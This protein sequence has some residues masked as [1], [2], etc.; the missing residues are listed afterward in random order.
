MVLPSVVA[1]RIAAGE[2]ISCPAAAVKKPV[3]SAL[4]AKA[5][6]LQVNVMDINLQGRNPSSAARYGGGSQGMGA[7]A[8]GRITMEG[9]L[10]LQPS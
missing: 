5:H 6:P 3:E 7:I 4:D 1:S 10:Y 2:V 8:A 9:N